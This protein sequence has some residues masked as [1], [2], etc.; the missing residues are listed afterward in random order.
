MAKSLPIQ[1]A[2]SLDKLI[3]SGAGKPEILRVG[4]R[5][6][7]DPSRGTIRFKKL[8]VMEATAYTP[9]DDGQSGI[10]ASGIPA[11]RGIIAVDP[12]KAVAL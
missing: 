8:L 12:S 9:F 1:A 2:D 7:N 5:E 10:T 3:E 6:S 11:R 4:T